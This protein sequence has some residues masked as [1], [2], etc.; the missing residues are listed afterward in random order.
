MPAIL[1]EAICRVETRMAIQVDIGPDTFWVP[2]S[3][4]DDNSEVY[5]KNHVGE[6]IVRTWWADKQN[7]PYTEV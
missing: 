1:G 7:L 4:I 2:K 5:E 3:V 6:L